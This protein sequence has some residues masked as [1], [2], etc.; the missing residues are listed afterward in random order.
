[1]VE[2]SRLVTMPAY[3]RLYIHIILSSM[4]LCLMPATGAAL[5]KSLQPMSALA[6]LGAIVEFN[7]TCVVNTTELNEEFF[8]IKWVVAGVLLPGDSNQAVISNGSLRIG[9]LQQR[10][11]EDHVSGVPVQ[12]AVLTRKPPW[13]ISLI[14]KSENATLT[15]YGETL[16]L[17]AIAYCIQAA[18]IIICRSS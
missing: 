8:D 17:C 3:Q 18:C 4:A 14:R 11:S 1:M 5:I 10:V 2:G 7:L 6:P 12:C 16:L 9:T 13:E 15:A